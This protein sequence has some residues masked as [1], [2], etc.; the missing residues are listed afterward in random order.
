M[1]VLL[2]D[3][4]EDGDTGSN[5]GGD[6]QADESPCCAGQSAAADDTGVGDLGVDHEI[7]NERQHQNDA[8]EDEHI[9]D[10]VRGSDLCFLRLVG[11]DELGIFEF[12][13]VV[14]FLQLDWAVGRLGQPEESIKR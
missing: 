11:C 3:D 2:A 13:L 1:L 5:D 12:E 10:R 4:A 14:A 7:D 6:D 8:E 9:A